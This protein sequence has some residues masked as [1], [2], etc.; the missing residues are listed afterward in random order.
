MLMKSQKDIAFCFKHIPVWK[1]KSVGLTQE[2]DGRET[3]LKYDSTQLPMIKSGQ[4]LQEQG[5]NSGW[6]PNATFRF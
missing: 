6:I 4:I 5:I 2:I 3:D 1:M